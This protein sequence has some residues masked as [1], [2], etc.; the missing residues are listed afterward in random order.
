MKENKCEVK[1][2][3]DKRQ[4]KKTQQISQNRKTITDKD[5]TGDKR[6]ERLHTWNLI[7][8]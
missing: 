3:T 1:E 4:R 8:I 6:S 2:P 5:V 7:Q